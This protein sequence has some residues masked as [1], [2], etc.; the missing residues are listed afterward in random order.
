MTLPNSAVFKWRR[1]DT[2]RTAA[3]LRE[4]SYDSFR[5]PLDLI[6]LV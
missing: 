1:E 6:G 2:L 4:M 5:R 3:G